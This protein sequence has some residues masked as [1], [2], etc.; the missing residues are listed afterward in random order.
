[1][2][3]ARAFVASV[4]GEPAPTA[5]SP[6]TATLALPPPSRSA[7]DMPRACPST[8]SAAVERPPH[9]GC[10]SGGRFMSAGSRPTIAPCPL[11]GFLEVAASGAAGPDT[12]PRPTQPV[13]GRQPQD[14]DVQRGEVCSA[15]P[16]RLAGTAAAPG[17][18]VRAVI[19]VMGRPRRDGAPARG[20]TA[21]RTPAGAAPCP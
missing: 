13:V 2:M 1:M 12:S 19:R 17:V 14:A 6:L 7:M 8:S 21:A 3:S 18:S 11:D 10:R 15:V 4:S 20:R 9:R 5:S 16:D